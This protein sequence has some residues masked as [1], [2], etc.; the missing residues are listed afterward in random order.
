MVLQSLAFGGYGH[1]LSLLSTIGL[2]LR[3]DSV[4]KKRLRPKSGS[5][6]RPEGVG[7]N[8]VAGIKAKTKMVK[9]E[10]KAQ[11]V[12]DRAL[13]RVAGGAHEIAQHGYV[14]FV[15]ADSPRVHGKAEPFGEFEVHTCIVKL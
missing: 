2:T 13:Q 7:I 15:G 9:R 12:Q 6:R 11:K 8:A 10:S 3:R 1:L 4:A 5:R 14:G